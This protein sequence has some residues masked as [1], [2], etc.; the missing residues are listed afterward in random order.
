[1]EMH[2]WPD[3]LRAAAYKNYNALTK[4]IP[5]VNYTI[6]LDQHNCLFKE[7][8]PINLI[9]P[10]IL[11]ISLSEVSYNSYY[12]SI[13]LRNSCGIIKNAYKDVNLDRVRGMIHLAQ[14]SALKRN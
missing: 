7:T 9:F 10:R 13:S 5:W 6:S 8:C 1:M 12:E 11:T 14:D 4:P 3:R 2:E